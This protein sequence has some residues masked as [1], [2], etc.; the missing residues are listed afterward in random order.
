MVWSEDTRNSYFYSPL[1]GA[2]A[3]RAEV[4]GEYS[5]W[6]SIPAEYMQCINGQAPEGPLPPNEVSPQ[7]PLAS[8]EPAPTPSASES[9][10]PSPSSSSTP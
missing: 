10:S 2:S 5:E 8:A 4:F 1:G 6:V 7:T 9:S 3:Y